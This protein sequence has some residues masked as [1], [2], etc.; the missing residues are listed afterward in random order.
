MKNKKVLITSV[1]LTILFLVFSFFFIFSNRSEDT[2]VFRSYTAEVFYS[3]DCGC[4][5][6]YIKYLKDK[7]F[8]VKPIPMGNIESVKYELKIPQNL[9]SCHTTKIDKYFI[10]GHVP[11]EAIK[12]LL[13][14]RP[15]IDGIALPGMPYGSP[16]MS[17]FKSTTFEVYKIIKGQSED[18][19][20]RV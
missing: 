20:I 13:E 9:W 3:P 11:I 17:G 5:A 14:E 19:F 10:E 16:G 1:I 2:T 8:N 15:D 12:K 4:C 18:V 6:N 7:G